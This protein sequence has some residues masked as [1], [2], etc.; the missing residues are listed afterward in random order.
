[1]LSD[2]PFVFSV[3]TIFSISKRNG[4]KKSAE[5]RVYECVIVEGEKSVFF[6][7]LPYTQ[8][9]VLFST[10]CSCF[11]II[12]TAATTTTSIK[13]NFFYCPFDLFFVFC[14]YKLKGSFLKRIFRYRHTVLYCLRG[15]AMP[16]RNCHGTAA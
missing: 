4:G 3:T 9:F 16:W 11:N 12:F 1:M 5:N 8:N 15:Y 14:P 2:F 7:P 13:K 10:Q 6:S